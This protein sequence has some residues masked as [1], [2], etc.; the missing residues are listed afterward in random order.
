M[1]SSLHTSFPLVSLLPLSKPLQT[2]SICYFHFLSSKSFLNLHQLGFHL[3]YCGEIV[4]LKICNEIHVVISNDQLL[5]LYLTWPINSS[6][7]SSSSLLVNLLDFVFN[8]SLVFLSF[9]SLLFLNLLCRL[10][11]I[12]M[13]SRS[14]SG[15]EFTSFPGQLSLFTFTH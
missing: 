14:L 2:F 3:H 8:G 7:W 15:L 11:F 1:E 13:N 10:L 9:Y 6:G 4:L 5:A 12:F